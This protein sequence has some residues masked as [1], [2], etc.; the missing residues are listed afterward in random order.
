MK[1]ITPTA[2]DLIIFKAAPDQVFMLLEDPDEDREAPLWLKC[3]IEKDAL[4]KLHKAIYQGYGK[5]PVFVVPV[6]EHPVRGEHD[7]VIEH[8]GRSLTIRYMQEILTPCRAVR[9]AR[10]VGSVPVVVLDKLI[11]KPHAGWSGGTWMAVSA[12]HREVLEKLARVIEELEKLFNRS[13]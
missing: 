4:R 2:G 5:N 10:I 11:E 9:D 13:I 7:L 1:N 3:D 8:E 12:E 6:D